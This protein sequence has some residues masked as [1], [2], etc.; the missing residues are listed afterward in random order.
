MNIKIIISVTLVIF[1]QFSG[2]SQSTYLVGTLPG[3]NFNKGLEKNWAL[4][5]KWE[6]RQI[7]RQGEF[8]S[9]PD[10]NISFVL[11]DISAIIA[12]KVGFNSRLGGGYLLRIRK[13]G[14]YHRLIQQYTIVSIL[15]QFRLA[16]RFSTDQ[17]FSSEDANTF[18]LRYRI[19]AEI[20]LNGQSVN[21]GEFYTKINNE[22]LNSWQDNNYDFE[23]RIVPVLGFNFSDVN[24]LEIGPDYRVNSFLKGD[25]RNSFWFTINWFL[26]ID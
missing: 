11:S 5:F 23:L 15:D 21:A 25:A 2:L 19:T 20:P 26:K 18:R 4:N 6:S 1:F 16:H 24:K 8:D 3:L 9:T 7:F 22:Y 12:K 13:S 17:T 10:K 14:L